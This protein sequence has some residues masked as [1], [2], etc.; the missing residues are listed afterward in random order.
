MIDIPLSAMVQ[1]GQTA[2]GGLTEMVADMLAGFLHGADY[3]VKADVTGTG[4]QGRQ[5]ESIHST[6]GGDGISL[7][8]GN[9][10]ETANGIA[11]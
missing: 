9:L 1:T 8:T 2:L 6:L 10:H 5:V 3:H 4:Q 7:D 11:G